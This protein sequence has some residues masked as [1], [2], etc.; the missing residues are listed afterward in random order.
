M[1]PIGDTRRRFGFPW[2][3]V[4][5]L[6]VFLVFFLYERRVPLDQS[7]L[8]LKPWELPAGAYLALLTKAL[9]GLFVQGPFWFKAIV[10]LV[11]LWVLGNKVEDACG[12]WGLLSIT[13]MSAVSGAAIRI[14]VDP[15]LYGPFGDKPIYG[16]VGAIAGLFGAYTVLYAFRPILA[17]LPPMVARLTPVPVVIHLLYWAAL[18]F[19]NVDFPNLTTLRLGAVSF[20]MTWPMVGALLMGLAIGMLFA[21]REYLYYKLLAAKAALARR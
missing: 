11:Y 10:N 15:V 12:P 2:M 9:T 21:R 4:M 16:L 20:H 18:E 17:W 3:T 19:V 1:I 14:I 6:V 8:S 13:L 5:L 7:G